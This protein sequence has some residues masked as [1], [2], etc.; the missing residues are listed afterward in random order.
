MP[1]FPSSGVPVQSL[2]VIRTP[3][4]R[5]T[6][7]LLLL[8]FCLPASLVL[9]AQPPDTVIDPGGPEVQRADP[10]RRGNL[11]SGA[12]RIRLNG[13]TYYYSG[14]YFYRRDSD[15]YLRVEPPLGAELSFVP[16]GGRGFT[17]DDDRYFLS[18]TGTFYRFDPRRRTY[19]VVTPPYEWRRYY[20]GSVIDAYEDEL[21][22]ESGD[23]DDDIRRYLDDPDIPRAYPPGAIA[24]EQLGNQRRDWREPRYEGEGEPYRLDP[25]SNRN[26]PYA[27]VR[28]PQSVGG[29]RYD[30][31]ALRESYCRQRAASAA[32]ESTLKDQQL[33]LYQRAYRDCIQ[34]YE[35]QR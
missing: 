18:G 15:G 7:S 8:L 4:N 34:R 9:A 30:T 11:P 33:R 25:R 29:E 32:R 31:R 17:I 20:N 35:R 24:E 14:G 28:P 22:G 2:S 26:R 5:R 6:F 16:G 12:D 3:V 10:N 19:T 1:V 27:D 23:E 21:Y 13:Q